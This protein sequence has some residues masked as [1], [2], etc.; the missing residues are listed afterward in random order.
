MVRG[1]RKGWSCKAIRRLQC[2][3]SRL[4]GRCRRGGSAS[5]RC[6]SGLVSVMVIR[7]SGDLEGREEMKDEV[8]G[9]SLELCRWD[10]YRGYCDDFLEPLGK[11]WRRPLELLRLQLRET[12]LLL[13]LL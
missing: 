5:S 10:M 4:R 8:R 12:R 7:R 13:L 6:G 2:W 9:R 1:R 11:R 3:C